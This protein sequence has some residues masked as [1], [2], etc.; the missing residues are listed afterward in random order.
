MKN[1][2]VVAVATGDKSVSKEKLAYL[3]VL[4][5]NLE[6]EADFFILGN[7]PFGIIIG[8]PTLNPPEGVLRFRAEEVRIVYQVQ[9]SILLV[10]S[11][12]SQ[13]RE[14]IGCSDRKDFTSGMIMRSQF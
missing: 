13:V 9:Y 10:L 4:F 7:I 8:Y 12:Y 1:P 2:K 14:L 3:P 11:D 5:V 6:A